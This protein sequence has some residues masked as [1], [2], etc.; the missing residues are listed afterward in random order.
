MEFP[1]ELFDKHKRNMEFLALE[2]LRAYYFERWKTHRE[3]LWN[4]PPV[5]DRFF[6]TLVRASWSQYGGC[7]GGLIM[8]NGTPNQ[9]MSCNIGVLERAGLIDGFIPTELGWLMLERFARE[10]AKFP[11]GYKF[12]DGTIYHWPNQKACI[13]AYSGRR[14]A[15]R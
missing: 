4:S 12:E 1:T 13:G 11:E 10:E 8:A 15:R 2:E 5:H 3:F 6:K 14:E 7:K 9:T